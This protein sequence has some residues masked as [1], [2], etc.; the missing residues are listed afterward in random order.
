MS[1]IAAGLLAVI[2]SMGA[3]GGSGEPELPATTKSRMAFQGANNA[4]T[5]TDDYPG[6]V[7]TANGNAKLSTTSPTF[8]V[9]SLSL[10]DDTSYLSASD[11]L[12]ALVAGTQDFA[13]EFWFRTTQPFTLLDLQGDEEGGLVIAAFN[14]AQLFIYTN[15]GPYIEFDGTALG[16]HYNTG[17]PIYICLQRDAGK[18]NYYFNSTY[19]AAGM[20][21]NT[22]DYSRT[23]T[24]ATIGRRQ[25]SP[26]SRP[27]I[28]N[29]DAFRATIGAAVHARANLASTPVPDWI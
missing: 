23:P 18:L 26:S 16:L 4:T 2:T 15:A 14:S 21:D 1:P 25:S 20:A 13:F 8:G 19:L 24:L 29:V 7:W 9:S 12:T 22:F 3:G 27:G 5:V 11:A 6:R 10:P 17:A 28:G